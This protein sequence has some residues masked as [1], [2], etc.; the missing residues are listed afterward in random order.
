LDT[1]EVP[2]WPPNRIETKSASTINA[3]HDI[4]ITDPPYAGGINYH[5]ITEFFIAW[6]RKNPPPPFDQWIWDSRRD[7]AFKGK[8][9]AFSPRYGSGLC[10]HD[11]AYAG[12]WR[13]SRDVS[14]IRTQGSGPISAPSSGP[15]A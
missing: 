15:L 8:D 3:A 7:L 9:E 1:S 2:I 6:L 14:P 12:Q 11:E 10:R 4:G 13:A 5:E